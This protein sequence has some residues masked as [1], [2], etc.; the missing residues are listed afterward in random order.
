[1]ARDE[2]YTLLVCTASGERLRLM[3]PDEV[4]ALRSALESGATSRISGER[5][6]G[7][8]E[9]ALTADEHAV[10]YPVVGG[11]PYLL[12]EDGIPLAR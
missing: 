3:G 9:A 12:P 8:L 2:L 1:M 10:A 4:G 5:L 11:L 7:P 6:S